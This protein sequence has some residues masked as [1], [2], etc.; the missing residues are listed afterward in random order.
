[1]KKMSY[2]DEVRL[3]DTVNAILSDIKGGTTPENAVIKMASEQKMSGEK[4][5]RL[6]ETVNKIMSIHYLAEAD[7]SKKAS[8][9]HLI[10]TQEVLRQLSDKNNIAAK[11]RTFAKV[12]NEYIPHM[13]DI[14]VLRKHYSLDKKSMAIISLDR[15]KAKLAAD[16]IKME[17]VLGTVDHKSD[18]ARMAG[19]DCQCEMADLVKM[20]AQSGNADAVDLAKY[21]TATY[22]EEGK[23]L[24]KMIAEAME[25]HS[26]SDDDDEHDEDD[27]KE[28]TSFKE[29][30]ASY[31]VGTGSPLQNAADSLMTKVH[32]YA[33]KKLAADAAIKEAAALFGDIANDLAAVQGAGRTVVDKPEGI[34]KDIEDPISLPMA[35]KMNDLEV[36]DMFANMYLGDEFLSQYDPITVQ[37][38]FNT[39]I[40]A[41]PALVKRRNS[42]ALIKAMV[43][44]LITSNNQIDP[45]EVKNM[46]DINKAVTEARAK[47]ENSIWS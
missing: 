27:F 7:P 18:E 4:V 16:Q 1:M 36:K 17:E 25:D 41:V 3:A 6:C 46:V 9:F 43:K 33:E 12:A 29:A 13:D 5:A 15:L 11:K 2:M 30:S 35:R 22:G 37:N 14:E 42:D 47:E 19:E 44:R 21:V 10:D 34:S 26:E 38:A 39:V 23:T 45:L 40:Q 28:E 31:W 24:I 20:V 32:L 8:A